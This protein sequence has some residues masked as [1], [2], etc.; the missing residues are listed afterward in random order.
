MFGRKWKGHSEGLRAISCACGCIAAP[1]LILM[2]MS[3]PAPA[4]DNSQA[5]GKASDTKELK[6]P[7]AFYNDSFG[8]AAGYVYGGT[9]FPQRQSTV[10]ATVITGSNSALAFYLLSWDIRVPCTERLFSM[11]ST[12]GT[13]GKAWR[14]F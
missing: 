5:T 3:Y 11:R 4:Q 14:W 7:C 1:L 8:A 12:G 10:L 2:F 9:G 13:C 6:I